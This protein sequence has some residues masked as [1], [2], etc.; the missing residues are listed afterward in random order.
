MGVDRSAHRTNRARIKETIRNECR[1][2]EAAPDL[3]WLPVLQGNTLAERA[4]DLRL[5]T[6]IG[7]LPGHYAGIGSICGRGVAPARETIKWYR[8]QLPGCQFHPFGVHIQ[9]LDDPAAKC[10][11]R[12]WDSYA[13]NW[14]RGQKDM[15]RPPECYHRPGET[16]TTYTHRLAAFYWK[17][18]VLP[19][20]LRR[21]LPLPAKW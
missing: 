13:W 18:T 4:F 14:G 6:R 9:A 3:P 12:S 20:L 8:W 15:D 17:N 11:V 2:R 19:R 21:Q 1:C 16:W 10:A 5:R 7:M